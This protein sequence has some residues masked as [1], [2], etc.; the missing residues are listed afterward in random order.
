MQ[1]LS[2]CPLKGEFLDASQFEFQLGYA[3]FGCILKRGRRTRIKGLEIVASVV[4][5]KRPGFL[6][7]SRYFD[8]GIGCFSGHSK[9]TDRVF[10][11]GWALEE[12]TIGDTVSEDNLEQIGTF[13]EETREK[14]IDGVVEGALH[15]DE[16]GIS[17]DIEV[18]TRDHSDLQE[19]KKGRVDVRQL[20]QTLQLAECVEDVE[21]VLKDKDELPLQVFSSIIRGFGRENRLEPA[22]AIV[23]WL[24]KKSKENSDFD[25]PNLFIYNSLLGAVKVSG[26]L[27]KVDIVMNDMED[28]GISPNVVTY[29]TLMGIYLDQGR[30]VEA[31]NLFEDIQH[32]GLSPSPASYSTALLAYRRKEDGNGALKFFL[33]FKEKYMNGELQGNDGE[34]WDSEFPKFENFTARICYQVMRRWLVKDGNFTTNVLKLLIEM[35]KADLPPSREEYERLIWACTREEHYVVAKE[36]YTRIRER[37]SDISLSVCNHIIWL[38]GK[39]KK[40]WAALEIY[41]DLLDQGPKPNNLSHEIIISHFNVLL[42]AARKRGIWRWG[43]RLLDRKS[44]V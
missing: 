32:K 20:A 16:S 26:E 3:S 37:Y 28:A 6:F 43:I 42:S 10:P 24:K 25:G 23:E 9:T 4:A 18:K 12:R 36:L 21:S 38:M 34:D 13:S 41:E 17:G 19:E 1:A 15:M 30:A 27:D 11:L 5:L 22:M 35:D 44:V 39:A 8:L 40:W 33:S 7:S 31:L 2:I 29:N 14:V